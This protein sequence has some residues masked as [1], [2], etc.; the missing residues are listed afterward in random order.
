MAGVAGVAALSGCA[1]G[2]STPVGD[3][4][5]S[6]AP[7]PPGGDVLGPGTVLDDG[8]GAQL[9]LGGVMESYP[10]QCSGLPLAGWEWEAVAGWEEA[11]DVRWGAYAVQGAYDGA[12]LTVTAPPILLAL[13]D[14]MAP[15]DPTGGVAG[16]TDEAML[17][18]IQEAVHDRLGTDALSSG[19]RDGYLWVTVAW[20]DGTLQADADA[21]WGEDVVIVQSALTPVG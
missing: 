16:E 15:E 21:E 11:G 9:C 19:P 4:F 6:R 1:S 14:P 7:T 8:S 17:V 18:Q 12:T 20:D 10:P 2:P 13:Y 5:G 3:V